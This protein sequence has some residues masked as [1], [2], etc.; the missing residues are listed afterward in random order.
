[1]N[2]IKLNGLIFG[3]EAFEQ[4]KHLFSCSMNH[5]EM[6]QKQEVK[7]G[8]VLSQLWMDFRCKIFMS[9]VYSRSCQRP[10]EEMGKA[11]LEAVDFGCHV[12]CFSCIVKNQQGAGVDCAPPSFSQGNEVDAR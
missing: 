5:E 9:M 6:T 1:M 7:M 8:N 10:P 11:F 3:Y 4:R 2:H 12:N